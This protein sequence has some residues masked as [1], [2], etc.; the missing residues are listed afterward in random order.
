[1]KIHLGTVL[2]PGQERPAENAKSPEEH[3]YGF[4]QGQTP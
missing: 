4:P 3:L 1:M 2:L